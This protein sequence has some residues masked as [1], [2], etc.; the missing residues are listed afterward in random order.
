MLAGAVRDAAASCA[1][2]AAPKRRREDER[3]A[4]ARR[5]LE[6]QVAA[7]HAG[8]AAAD[9]EAEARAAVLAR[10]RAVGLAEGLEQPPLLLRRD[11]DAGVAHA[12]AQAAPVRRTGPSPL[13]RPRLHPHHHLAL[14]RELERVADQVRQ[15]L[16][17]AQGVADE[18]VGHVRAGRA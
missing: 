10:G 17:E 9:R 14:R 18:P 8:E 16:P 4:D 2:P 11:A 3:R 6:R 7:H 15:H 5:A 1:R 13:G 12:D